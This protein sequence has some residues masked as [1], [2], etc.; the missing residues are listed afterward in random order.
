MK[1]IKFRMTGTCPLML[2]NPQT[3]NPMNEFTKAIS[4]LTSKRKKTD[5]DQNEI[6]HLKFLAS[7]YWNNKGQYFLPANMI[8]KSFEAGAKEN[9]LGQMK[10]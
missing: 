1:S 10:I 9:K 6:F 8:A 5:E 4:A 7:C 2:N 3:V